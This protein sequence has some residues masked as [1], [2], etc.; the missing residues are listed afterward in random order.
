MDFSKEQR[1]EKYLASPKNIKSAYAAP[2]TGELLEKLAKKI[3]LP[4][5]KYK[6]YA[7]AVGDL[8]LGLIKPNQLSEHLVAS[9]VIPKPQADSI[10]PEINSFVDSLKLT[11]KQNTANENEIEIKGNKV[12]STDKVDKVEPIKTFAAD[13]E[14]VHGYGVYLGEKAEDNK[15]SGSDEP[16]HRTEQDSVLVPKPPVE[17]VSQETEPKP[18]E[19][20]PAKK[21]PD[22]PAADVKPEVKSENP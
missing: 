8:I 10:A 21:L 17:P 14:K 6:D 4:D 20:L 15:G 13:Y 7:L 5:Q 1:K 11:K 12:K 18:K 22:Q 16:V 9:V 2:E 3:N 19:E